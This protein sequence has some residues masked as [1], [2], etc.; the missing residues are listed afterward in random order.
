MKERKAGILVLLVTYLLVFACVFGLVRLYSDAS[1]FY[2]WSL[3]VLCPTLLWVWAVTSWGGT[4]VFA[5][6]KRE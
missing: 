6:A 2:Y 1:G 3:I 4:Q 5:N